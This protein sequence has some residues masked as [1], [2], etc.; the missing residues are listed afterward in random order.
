MSDANAH[1]PVRLIC[2]GLACITFVLYLPVFHH[3]FT[4]YDDL[5]Y[6][7]RS[8]HVAAGLTW[9][10]IA[11]AFRSGYASNWHPLT[12]ISHMVD[13]QI[14][15]LQPAGH[16]LT[17]VLFHIANTILLFLVLMKLTRTMWPCAFVA[18]LFAWHPMHVESVAWAAERKDVLSAFFFMLTLGSYWRYTRAVRDAKP[19]SRR[20]L[21][22]LFLFALGLMSKP[23]LVTVPFLLLLLDFWPLERI[24]GFGFRHV[25]REMNET[26]AEHAKS[27]LLR[28][29]LEKVPFLILSA[30]SSVATFIAQKAG[31]AMAPL[32]SLPLRFRIAN[33]V[34]AYVRYV[35]KAIWP[36]DLAVLYPLDLHLPFWQVAGA[37]LILVLVTLW[38][39]VLVRRRPYLLVGWLWFLG[40]LVPVIGLVQVGNQSMADRYSYI[41]FIGLFIM[42]AWGLWDLLSN[43]AQRAIVFAGATTVTSVACLYLTSLQVRVW[44]NADTL[45]THAIQTTRGNFVA[46]NQLGLYLADQGRLPEAIAK[47]RAAL[48]M[49]PSYDEALNN[50]GSALAKQGR[51][52]DAIACY[53]AALKIQPRRPGIHN[54]WGVAL[55]DMG[56]LDEAVA[57]YLEAL[58]LKPD[59]AEGHYNLANALALS[60]KPAQAIEHY[61]QALALNPMLAEAHYNLGNVLSD[62]GKWTEA[63]EHYF[64]ATQLKPSYAEAHNNLGFALARFARLDEAIAEYSVALQLKPNHWTAHYNLGNALAEQGKWDEAITNY[65]AALQVKPDLADVHYRL[66]F[67]LSQEGRWAEACSELSMALQLKPDRALFH[68]QLAAALHRRGQTREAISHYREAIRLKP[69]Y[70]EALNDL[71]WILATHPDPALRDGKE[72]VQRAEEACEKAGQQQASLLETLAAAYA[73]AG[74]FDEA[75]TAAG[76]AR[77]LAV[78]TGQKELAAKIQKLIERFHVG[79]AW[80]E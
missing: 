75:T 43:T 67:A 21:L 51:S 44:E 64:K 12:W 54:N 50:L 49:N 9:P 74:R 19:T 16:Y 23:M 69:D 33:A 26:D 77:E 80:R 76:K 3:D 39:V 15:G 18:A 65:T 20:Y 17:N 55:A 45:F 71:A 11:W 28:L 66:G 60:A 31:G 46:Y 62:D 35:V 34:V 56:R 14:Y 79:E 38:G 42:A 32:E 47:Y 59:Y 29:V 52:A 57:H 73:E 5:E 58:K 1:R 10:G 72:A 8:P 68:C 24:S 61:R 53:E 36:T 63:L 4:N 27:S 37:C 78:S 41:P 2:L 13:C 22:T 25:N 70:A 40:T 6:I 48:T 30:G 7:T